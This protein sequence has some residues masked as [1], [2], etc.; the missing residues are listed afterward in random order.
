MNVRR[1]RDPS[2]DRIAPPLATLAEL[3]LVFATRGPRPAIVA[4]Q[5]SGVDTLT[6]A[7]LATRVGRMAQGLRARGVAHGD[8][9]ALWAPNSPEWIVSYFAIVAAGASAV[10]LDHQ[11]P[12]A[13][14]HRLASDPDG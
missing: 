12:A 6:Y 9:V 2:S 3:S 5:R 4:F 10:P 13:S 8:R 11:A 1:A 7:E 14:H